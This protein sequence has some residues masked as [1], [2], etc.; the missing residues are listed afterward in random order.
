MHVHVQVFY[1]DIANI[2]WDGTRREQSI[3]CKNDW[4]A[5]IQPNKLKTYKVYKAGPI[6]N[7]VIEKLNFINDTIQPNKLKT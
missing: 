5:T 3:K 6:V 1:Q 4:T 2:S 7:S